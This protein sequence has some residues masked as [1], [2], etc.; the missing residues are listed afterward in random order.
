MPM[1]N[2]CRE[3][4]RSA[5]YCLAVREGDVRERLKGAHRYLRMLSEEELPQNLREEWGSILYELTKR[6]PELGPQGDVWQTAL[7]HTLGSIKNVT[8]RRI[9][10]RIYALAQHAK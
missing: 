6:G 7:D 8:G 2:R 5:L 4:L 9:A 1:N 10:E 3:K